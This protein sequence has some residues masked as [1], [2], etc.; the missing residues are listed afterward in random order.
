[1][2]QNLKPEE[3]E[4]VKLVQYFKKRALVLITE[5][6]LEEDYRQMLETCDKLTGTT[7]SARKEQGYHHC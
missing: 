3:R 2:E 4:L 7:F 1:M 6:K 5:N